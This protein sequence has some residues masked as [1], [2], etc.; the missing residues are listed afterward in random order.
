MTLKMELEKELA[1]P[2]S[3]PPD[4]RRVFAERNAERVADG[5]WG[6]GVSRFIVTGLFVDDVDTVYTHV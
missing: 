3:T 5:R 2:Q 1:Q 4:G 6:I